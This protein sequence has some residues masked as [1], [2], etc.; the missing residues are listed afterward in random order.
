[1]PVTKSAKKA[2]RVSRR[3]E[4]VNQKIKRQW[5]AAVKTV[6]TNPTGQNLKKVFSELDIAAKKGI[7]HTN[8]AARLK[9]RL[10]KLVPQKPRK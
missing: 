10:T 8:K 1:M 2:L 4:A 5:K 9:S 6:R 7:I 3:K